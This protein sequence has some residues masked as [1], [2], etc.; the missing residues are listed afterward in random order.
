[1]RP[2]Q[3]RVRQMSAVVRLRALQ[4][5]KSELVYAQQLKALQQSQSTLREKQ[6]GYGQVLERYQRQQGEGL[7]LDPQLHEQRLQGLLAMHATVLEQES[8]VDEARS[9][10]QSAH[11]ALNEA[12][13]EERIAQKAHT[14]AKEALARYLD[15]QELID[16]FDAQ[17][18][19][20]SHGV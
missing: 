17:Q 14:T 10:F 7:M 9:S 13:V 19:G 2:E 1:M 11:S 3:K 16:V 8:R 20:G 4:S 15:A 18:A 12:R 5:E 6:A